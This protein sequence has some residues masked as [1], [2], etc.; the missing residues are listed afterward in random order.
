M[1]DGRASTAGVVS[2][3]LV[4]LTRFSTA[5]PALVCVLALVLVAVSLAG[6]ARS[7]RINTDTAGL[8]DARVP[9][10]T[11]S[12]AFRAAFPLRS[13]QLIVVVD[14]PTGGL[15]EI[16]AERLAAAMRTS[17]LFR[18]VERPDAEAFLRSHALLYRSPQALAS[19]SDSLSAAQPLIAAMTAAP[20][21]PGLADAL[22]LALD[23]RGGEPPAMVDTF[24][25][26]MA[27]AAEASLD[28]R[29]APFDAS[30]LLDTSDPLGSRRFVVADTVVDYGKLGGGGE[31]L[32]AVHAMAR[33]LGLTPG[34]GTTVR[35]TGGPALDS[36]ELASVESGMGVAAVLSFSLVTLLLIVALGSG[37]LI[38]GVLC[39]LVAG[40]IVTGGLATLMIGTLNLISVA[41]AVLFVGLGVDFG[42]HF[43]L[44]VR[45]AL[46]RQAPLQAALEEAAGAV[47]PPLALSALC[48]AIGFLSFLPTVYRGMAEL[49]LI[50]ASGMAVAMVANLTLLPALLRLLPPRLRS[51]GAVRGP[52]ARFG[53]ALLGHRFAVR[54]AGIAVTVLA[55]AGAVT[56]TRFDVNPLNLQDPGAE[57]VRTYRSLADNPLTTPYHIEI[58][59]GSE[60]E[61][62]A[63][64]GRLAAL[65][66]VGSTRTV[67]SFIPKDQ[68][69]KLALLEDLALVLGPALDEPGPPPDDAAR[70]QAVERLIGVLD[71]APASVSASKRLAASLQSVTEAPPA[72]LAGLER[73]LT[74]DLGQR[75]ATLRTAILDATPVTREDLPESLVRQWIAPDGRARVEVAAAPAFAG[76][77]AASLE[78]FADAVRAV[79]P[80]ASGAPVLVTQGART[81]IRAFLEATAITF[82]LL[83]VV[84]AVVQRRT[85]DVILTLGSLGVAG[86]W[87]FGVAAVLGIAVN[88]AN[89][90]VLPLLFGL[91]VSSAI[92]MVERMR[93]N[94]G[95]ARA[96]L[97]SSTPR[98]VLFSALTTI[99][100][101]GSLAISPHRGT[102]SM[103]L[104]LA[105]AI[106]ATLIVTLILLPA[107]LDRSPAR[108]D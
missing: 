52:F 68:D 89:V 49:G 12:L 86:A 36:E 80:H 97:G 15:A 32:R 60:D 11:D 2:A 4:S 9:Y 34:S 72:T 90:I 107:F 85:G 108:R 50:A 98:A 99:A 37:R 42:I 70:R 19:L 1:P 44:R 61:A 14:A 58:L 7:L 106:V 57:A 25:G 30:A 26:R 62:E 20:G 102:A 40:L 41:F 16:A 65:P 75:F 78:A 103:G 104:M 29:P 27:D 79:A 63:L 10:R 105:I 76:D 56:G 95:D 55:L 13:E 74:A 96:L 81:V 93:Q 6:M 53:A 39:T 77:D 45:E 82:G 100:S 88:F 48:A 64:A 59:A 73:D 31:A 43:A 69:E 84:L 8:I 91:G 28:G 71:D 23:R 38:L 35:L 46:A 51:A 21:L 67:R 3:S 5:R 17:P 47:G 83:V 18:G 101:F 66:E 92:H 33:D 87:T 94:G 22:S 54:A 24:I